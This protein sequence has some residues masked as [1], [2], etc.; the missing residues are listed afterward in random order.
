MV[1]LHLR[2][3][4]W[5]SF[6]I[7]VIT[8]CVSRSAEDEESQPV[9]IQYDAGPC[10]LKDLRQIFA[11]RDRG[12]RLWFG[13]EVTLKCECHVSYYKG[14]TAMKWIEVGGTT[15]TNQHQRHPRY[16][17][18]HIAFFDSED[19]LIGCEGDVLV[20]AKAGDEP[21]TRSRRV[22]IPAGV[23]AKI[24]AYRS[25]FYESDE[26]IGAL[27]SPAIG[28]SDTTSGKQEPL[29][30]SLKI[31]GEHRTLFAGLGNGI[32]VYAVDGKCR[33]WDRKRRNTESP[34]VEIGERSSSQA[35]M[36]FR[37]DNSEDIFVYYTLTNHTDANRCQDMYVAFFD[38]EG[39]LV[40][41]ASQNFRTAPRETT[42]SLKVLES[43]GMTFTPR[44]VLAAFLTQVPQDEYKRV[45]YFKATM[46]VYDAAT[47]DSKVTVKP[48]G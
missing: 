29:K 14:D 7:V 39:H 8:T 6:A 44:S 26:P 10:A 11:G 3:C 48:S 31:T 20:K 17:A 38:A 41:S 25:A 45:S 21:Q 24:A 37:S 40:G 30:P 43:E 1:T 28:N 34:P 18:H 22:P 47:R 4:F 35:Q 23:E 5:V 16:Y 33:V 46:Y 27:R 12:L 13:Q 2:T 19:N 32:K 9:V 42:P 15:S 36:Y